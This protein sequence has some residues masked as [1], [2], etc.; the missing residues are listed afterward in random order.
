MHR[1]NRSTTTEIVQDLHI[2]LLCP[3]SADISNFPL[4]MTSTLT[5]LLSETPCL[6]VKVLFP[7]DIAIANC[8]YLQAQLRQ[9]IRAALQYPHFA[10][11]QSGLCW[12]QEELFLAPSVPG[13]RV[14]EPVFLTILY[15]LSFSLCLPK[16]GLTPGCC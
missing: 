7:G 3:S 10:P 5:R 9:C 4:L 6:H 1:A 2:F 13:V 16:E 12:L 8:P 14:Q 11:F 15:S